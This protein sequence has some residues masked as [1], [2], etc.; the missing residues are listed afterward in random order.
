MLQVLHAESLD[1][2]NRRM[3]A[4]FH[5]KYVKKQNRINQNQTQAN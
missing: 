4:D 3:S 2:A 5:S 1:E